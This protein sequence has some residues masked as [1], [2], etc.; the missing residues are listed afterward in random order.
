MNDGKLQWHPAFGAACRIELAEDAQDLIFEE[1][2]PLSKKPMQ[3]DV[4]IIKKLKNKQLHKNIGHIFKTHNIIEYKAPKDY[5]SVNDFYKVYGYACFYLADTNRVLEIP[6]SEVTITYACYHYPRK[7][8]NYIY[9]KRGITIE[10]YE[11]GIYY[12]KNDDFAMQLIIIPWLSHADNYW[13]QS[14]RDDLKSGG[15]I[16]ELIE[17]YETKKTSPNYQAMMDLIIRAN[18]KEVEVEKAM[19]DALKELFADELRESRED[20]M[21]KG[22]QRGSEQMLLLTQKLLRENRLDDLR[23]VTEDKAFREKLLKETR[24]SCH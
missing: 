3:I 8:L 19:C 23:R 10:K 21:R 18:W 1:E 5:L 7:M 9:R 14:L 12:L 13:L 2:H 16:R 24:I 4:L 20:G 17:N 6:S 22:M 15:E 11:N